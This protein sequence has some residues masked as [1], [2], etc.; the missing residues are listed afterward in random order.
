MKLSRAWL[1]HWAAC[2]EGVDTERRAGGEMSESDARI[3]GQ[4]NAL[5]DAQQLGYLD[6]RDDC[7]K[8]RDSETCTCGIMA[9]LP[10]AM[11]ELTPRRSA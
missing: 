2:S 6:H 3:E 5:V 1:Q 11:T 7:R 8:G 9:W 4:R 10:K